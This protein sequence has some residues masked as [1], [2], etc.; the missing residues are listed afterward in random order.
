MVYPS[1]SGDAPVVAVVTVML[2][3]VGGGGMTLNAGLFFEGSPATVAVS[4]YPLPAM[5]MR[6]SANLATPFTACAVSVP[7]S[8]APVGWAPSATVTKLSAPATRVPV[9]STTATRTGGRSCPAR[10]SLGGATK[11]TPAVGSWKNGVPPPPEN[12]LSKWQLATSATRAKTDRVFIAADGR[13]K[14][15][16][17]S[18]AWNDSVLRLHDLNRLDTPAESKQQVCCPLGRLVRRNTGAGSWEQGAERRGVSCSPLPAP[19][20]LY[21]RL[22]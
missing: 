21:N 4:V 13:C 19:C 20:S 16:T 11:V 1:R 5:S 8:F 18:P 6:R 12:N 2:P 3:L 22:R 15:R 17:A 7:L 10:A 14:G 9:E